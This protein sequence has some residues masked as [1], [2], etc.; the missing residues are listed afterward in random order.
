MGVSKKIITVIMA[1]ASVAFSLSPVNSAEVESY[2]N[3][4]TSFYNI[5]KEKYVVKDEYVTNQEQFY[6]WYSEERYNGD[7]VS[8]PVTVSEAHGYG[9]LITASMSEYDE[10]SKKYFDGM[11]RFYKAHTS[12][13]GPNL[14]SWQQSD[15]GTELIDG[16][17]NGSMTGGYCDS[18]ADGDMDI[19]Y[20]LLIADKVWGSEGEIDYY[21]EA[22]AV[23]NDIMTYEINH[24]NWTISLGDWV[25]ECDSND[26]FYSATRASD[27]I[28]QYM[29]VFA[30]VTGDQRWM[31]VYNSTY[32]IINDMV[33]EY[34]TGLLPDFIIKDK[35][36]KY[37]PAP[38]GFLEGEYDGAYSYNSCRIPWRISMD[39]IINKNE[40]ALLFSQAIN[41]FIINESGGDPWEIKAG[42][43]VDGT[44]LED[45]ND[46]CFTAPFLVAAKCGGNLEWEESLRDCI[47]N[48]GDD[49]YYGDTIKMLCL[50]VAADKWIVPEYNTGLKGD[51]NGDGSIDNND[52][53]LLRDYLT[54]KS[55]ISVEYYGEIDILND[56]KI[57]IF[58]MIALKRIILNEIEISGS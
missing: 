21:S 56:N 22:L 36:G 11:Y 2:C 5:W 31:N 44:Q 7:N 12:D 24:E 3:D 28:V 38:A 20:A 53:V 54:G 18:A 48:Y 55:D 14:M 43:S 8:V 1:V 13:I 32:K 30:E 40:N 9:M 49:V 10:Q 46:L 15:N 4:M 35:S 58:D 26:I 27:F 42:Y 16:A 41:S 29:P 47:V 52:I 51:I 37:V 45:Y 23:I 34:E 6:V 33:L 17:E 57:D 25:Y 50:I 39:Y 19:A